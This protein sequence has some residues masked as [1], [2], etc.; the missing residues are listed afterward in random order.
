MLKSVVSFAVGLFSV[1]AFA[2][3]MKAI[4]NSAD[5]EESGVFCQAIAKSS[6]GYEFRYLVHGAGQI[7]PDDL[8]RW[9]GDTKF[10]LQMFSPNDLVGKTLLN[11]VVPVRLDGGSGHVTYSIPGS[12]YG[13]E[14]DEAYY[15]HRIVVT[16]KISPTETLKATGE[17][18]M[19]D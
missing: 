9:Q 11:D 17:C 3:G 4:P 19:A 5:D 18:F 7:T 16:H 12:V 2:T 13:I 15:V 14:L 10:N 6:K 8:L 1:S